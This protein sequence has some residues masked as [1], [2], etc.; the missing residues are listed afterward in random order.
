M[1]D[2]WKAL[3]VGTDSSD[4]RCHSIFYTVSHKPDKV[5]Y[6]A[7]CGESP[8]VSVDARCHSSDARCHTSF[9]VGRVAM[10]MYYGECMEI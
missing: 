5:L 10:K 2:A 9:C 8:Y 1:L 4:A 3:M 7:F 6:R